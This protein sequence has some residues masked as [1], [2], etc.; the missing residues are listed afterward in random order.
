MCGHGSAQFPFIFA[1]RKCWTFILTL[2]PCLSNSLSRL[3]AFPPL[4][5]SFQYVLWVLRPPHPLSLLRTQDIPSFCIWFYVSVAMVTYNSFV[6]MAFLILFGRNTSLSLQLLI[7][8]VDRLSR[9]EFLNVAFLQG[10][11]FVSK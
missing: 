1:L 7:S 5:T 4:D 11:L 8:S 6:D 9:M 2:W 3:L 10:G